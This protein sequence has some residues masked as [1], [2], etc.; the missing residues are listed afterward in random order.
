MKKIVLVFLVAIFNSCTSDNDFNKGKRQL[1]MQGYS[2]VVNTGYTVFCCDE[3]DTFSTGFLCKDKSGNY[4]KGCFCS[5]P[6]KGIT[7]RFE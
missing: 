5:S 3:K 4:V 6:I 2:D 1:E 7:I